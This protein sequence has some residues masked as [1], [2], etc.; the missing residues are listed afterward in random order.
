MTTLQ[1]KDFSKPASGGPYAG[2]DRDKIFNLK[3]KDKKPFWIGAN[4]R[5]G[6]EVTGV[7]Y[8]AKKKQFTYE[9]GKGKTKK[10]ET[11]PVTKVFKDKDF[12]GGAGSGGGAE[13]TKFTE[14]MHC[15]YCAYVFNVK[16]GVCKSISDT[17]LKKAKPFVHADASLEECW[18]NGPKDWIE[19][20]VYIKTANKLYQVYGRKM[21]G[22]VYFH[23]GSKFM[24]NL[25]KAKTE[26]HKL[27]K[28]SKK[29]QAPGSFSHDKW[30]PGDI[31]ASTFGPNEEPLKEHT[32]S[33]GELNHAVYKFAQEGKLLGISLKKIAPTQATAKLAEFNSPKQQ[34][35]REKYQFKGFTYGKTGDFF[36]SQDIYLHTSQ[37]DVQFR[38]FG[39]ETSWQ[40]E[41][42]G[43]TAAGGKIGGGNV[44]FFTNQVIG[45]G[46]YTPFKDEKTLLAWVRKN[47]NKE[48]RT[49]LFELYAKHNKNSNKKKELLSENEFYKSL[50][51]KDFKFKNS[52]II[53]ME[54]LETLSKGSK[55]KKDDFIT[56][57][58]R[59]AQSD[60]DQSSYFVKLY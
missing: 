23:R 11:V 39:G 24:N 50:G 38:T 5:S 22:K 7:S 51:S 36:G 3:I 56:K 14:S 34:E 15:F 57:M 52:K 30:N 17:E 37:G 26:C 8:D 29:P 48:Y 19:S 46:I 13:D 1:S 18:S 54:F 49:R 28:K 25:Y 10:V 31:W 41:I 44:D 2:Q 58:F 21:K 6:K 45:S 27:D 59:Y 53:C 47:E 33:W 35:K 4:D 40:G 16:K 55:A 42:K 60:V 12:G 32:E 9:I 20:D 43:G